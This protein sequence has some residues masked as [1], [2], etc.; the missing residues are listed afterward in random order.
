MEKWEYQNNLCY[1]ENRVVIEPF[2]QRTASTVQST[3]LAKVPKR[4]LNRIKDWCMLIRSRHSAVSLLY[5]LQQINVH[6]L[7]KKY[8][9]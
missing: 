5:L 8:L 4:V 7:H 2:M 3:Y 1:L 6:H 9:K